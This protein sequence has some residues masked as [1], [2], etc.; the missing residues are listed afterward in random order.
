MA[1]VR[2]PGLFYDDHMDRGLPTPP[3]ERTTKHHVWIDP[4]HDAATELL[5]DAV[6]YADPMG[7][8]VEDQWGRNLRRA[9]IKTV[10]I[11]EEAGLERWRLPRT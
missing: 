5:N 10:A 9:A 3:A 8:E 1:A 2:V 11:L 7:P 6:H 4:A